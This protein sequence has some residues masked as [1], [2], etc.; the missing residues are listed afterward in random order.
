M[1]IILLFGP[2]FY[3]RIAKQQELIAAYRAKH[4]L[5]DLLAVNLEDDPE[6][7]RGARDFVRQPS[8]FVDSKVLVVRSPA[9]VEEKEWTATLR[10]AVGAKG[11]IVILSADTDPTK[12]FPFL[13]DRDVERQE[14][15]ELEGRMLEAFVLREA[16]AR[17][18][19]LEPSALRFF[20]TY[21]EAHSFRSAR[22]LSELEK[23]ALGKFAIP[24]TRADV[25][26]LVS[27]V[28]S[29]EIFRSV[30]V[31]GA[32]GRSDSDESSDSKRSSAL[33]RLAALEELLLRGEAPAKLF[34]LIGYQAGGGAVVALA[35]YDIAIKSG[36]LEYEEALTDFAIGSNGRWAIGEG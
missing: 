29:E 31:V 35:A 11:L 8:M 4:P 28:P 23:I 34:N 15:K 20:L 13:N 16:K 12:D 22:A 24:V 19:T 36:K 9:A 17:A 7:W 6:A 33:S 21:L 32:P 25:A 2:D 5:A 14:F 30:R 18:L 1:M 26:K 3:R 27:W 10:D